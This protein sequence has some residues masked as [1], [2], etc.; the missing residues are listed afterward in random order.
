MV[1]DS[2]IHDHSDGFFLVF[3]PNEPPEIVVEPSFRAIIEGE[4]V[5]FWCNASGIPK[6]NIIW[7]RLG[8]NLPDDALIQ[9]GLLTIASVGSDD[10][11]TYICTAVNSEGKGSFSAQLVVI[12]EH[13]PLMFFTNFI[14]KLVIL[15]F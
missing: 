13:A 4:K 14:T 7:E 12:G 6:P 11:G 15:F 9:N 1:R 2:I 3:V 8:S 5:R 10:A